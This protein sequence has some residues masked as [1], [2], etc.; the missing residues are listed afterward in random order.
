MAALFRLSIAAVMLLLLLLPLPLG[1]EHLGVGALARAQHGQWFV[2][3]VD[4]GGPAARA[5]LRVGDTVLALDGHRTLRKHITDPWLDFGQTHNWVVSRSGRT[6]HL[7]RTSTGA[8]LQPL[9]LL[10]IAL[11]YWAIGIVVLVRKPGDRLARQIFRFSVAMAGVLGLSTPAGNDVVWA[12]PPEILAYACLP[13]LFVQ[14]FT[15]ITTTGEPTARRRVIARGLWVAGLTAASG[16]AVSGFAGLPTYDLFRSLLLGAVAF[17]FMAGVASLVRARLRL[18]DCHV[19]RQVGVVLWGTVAAVAPVTILALLPSVG[20]GIP[21]VAP[22]LAAMTTICLP[23]GLGYAV[24]RHHLLDI[25]I[26]AGRTLIYGILAAVITIC[27]ASVVYLLSLIGLHETA[28]SA[29]L[30]ALLLTV[31]TLLF[32]KAQSRVRLLVDHVIYRDRYHHSRAVQHLAGSLTA[33]QSLD[34]ALAQI[35]EHLAGLFHCD[36]AAVMLRAPDGQHRVVTTSAGFRAPDRQRELLALAGAMPTNTPETWFPLIA[37]GETH[38]FLILGTGWNGPETTPEDRSLL[39]ATAAQIAVASSGALLVERLK[40]KVE[41]LELLRN[42]L[43]H[44]QDSERKRT[45]QEI[46]DGALQSVLQIVRHVDAAI[47][48]T[49]PNRRT[50]PF[51]AQLR[52]LAELAHDTVFTLRVACMELYP[53]ALGH[54][55]LVAALED[56][57][58]RTSREEN[59]SVCFRHQSFPTD[60]R[61]AE[62][63]EETLYRIVREALANAVRHARAGTVSVE[64]AIDG[65]GVMLTVRDDGR[66]FNPPK[67]VHTLLRTGHLGLVTMQERAEH[68]GGSMIVTSRPEA[69]TTIHIHLPVAVTRPVNQVPTEAGAAKETSHRHSAG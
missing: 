45:A 27:Y 65:T 44:V 54:L 11:V 51:I 19:R 57:S 41:E 40:S 42:Q 37:H 29:V 60:L 18:P 58:R 13:A 49:P 1:E 16:F 53:S 26:I 36:G 56:L 8:R 14:C 39:Q 68:L 43:L 35:T 24:L 28:R 34:Q 10:T 7:R 69:G 64:L 22:Q 2:F 17:G 55:G 15:G 32:N 5:G 52:E 61:L 46:H 20:G 6:V 66:G 63:A 9:L 12:N 50:L 21:P 23:A 62:N 33:G 47:T 48:M 67:S 3:Q 59:V 30:I 31:V 38:G 4:S 25:D